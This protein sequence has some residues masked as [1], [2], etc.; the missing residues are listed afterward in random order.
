MP[1]ER[2]SGGGFRASDSAGLRYP[3]GGVQAPPVEQDLDVVNDR[4]AGPGPGWPRP[5]V[6]ELLLQRGEEA[7]GD[8][9]IPALAKA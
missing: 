2:R 1:R 6:D 4:P 8:G 5:P 7:L 9:V 3:E